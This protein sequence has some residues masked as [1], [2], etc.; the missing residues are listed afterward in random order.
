MRQNKKYTTYIQI[1]IIVISVVAAVVVRWSETTRCGI[2]TRTYI[3]EIYA[4]N[5]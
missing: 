2:G 1:I 4:E 5:T 3:N